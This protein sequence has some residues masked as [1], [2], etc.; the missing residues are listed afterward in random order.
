MKITQKH[1]FALFLVGLGVI[2]FAYPLASFIVRYFGENLVLTVDI[3]II[4]W[5][6]ALRVL[7][8]VTALVF[9]Y[10]LLQKPP[11]E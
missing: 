4:E 7:G 11:Q 9:G 5:A 6:A 1:C 10:G 8:A 3:M 2:F